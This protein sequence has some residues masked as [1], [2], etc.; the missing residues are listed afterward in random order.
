MNRVLKVVYNRT[1]GMFVAVSE[2]GRA[3]TRRGG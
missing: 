2:L 3:C 1:K